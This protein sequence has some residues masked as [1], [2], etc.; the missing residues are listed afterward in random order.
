VNISLKELILIN[1][2]KLS[3]FS[4]VFFSWIILFIGDK[5]ITVKKKGAKKKGLQK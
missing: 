3:Q 1:I 5:M 2:L 4:I